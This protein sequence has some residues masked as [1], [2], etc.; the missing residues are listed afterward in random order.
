[1]NDDLIRAYLLSD[2]DRIRKLMPTTQQITAINYA[3]RFGKITS[4]D[5]ATAYGL[6]IQR[7]TMLLKSCYDKGYLKRRDDGCESGGQQF[8]YWCS[9]PVLK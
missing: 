6:T 2:R 3:K 1:M 9:L 5:I 7:A 8:T 4:N